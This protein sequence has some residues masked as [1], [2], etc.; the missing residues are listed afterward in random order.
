MASERRS[1]RQAKVIKKEPSFAIARSVTAEQEQEDP[2]NWIAIDLAKALPG[3]PI[4][5]SMQI[6]IEGVPDGARF[7]T[8]RNNGDKTWSLDPEDLAELSYLPPAGR[9]TENQSF[10]IRLLTYDPDGYQIAS[11]TAQVAVNVDGVTARRPIQLEHGE[12]GS[13][14]VDAIREFE[15]AQRLAEAERSWHEQE[16]ERIQQLETTWHNAM[17]ERL[18]A[19]EEEWRQ[20]EADRHQALNG[21]LTDLARRLR[22][23]EMEWHRVE[24]ERISAA[25]AQAADFT[26]QRFAAAEEQWRNE[27]E[28]QIAEVE[29]AAEERIAQARAEADKDAESRFNIHAAKFA[30]QLEDRQRS[31]L[32]QADARLKEMESA[33]ERLKLEA[34]ANRLANKREFSERQAAW[35][36]ERAA[37]LASASHDIE[38]ADKIAALEE[39]WRSEAQR[40][41]EEAEARIRR[42]AEQHLAQAEASW[43]QIAERRIV[44]A[45]RE[46]EDAAERRLAE[47]N[48]SV[49]ARSE[50]HVADMRGR[51]A[52]VERL[53]AEAE[54]RIALSEQQVSQAVVERQRAEQELA[55]AGQRFQEEYDRRLREAEGAWHAA[56]SDQLTAAQAAWTAA[57]AERLAEAQALWMSDEDERLQTA[58]A[59]ERVMLAGSDVGQMLNQTESRWREAEAERLKAAEERWKMEEDQRVAAAVAAAHEDMERMVEARLHRELAVDAR[60]LV[61]RSGRGNVSSLLRFAAGGAAAATIAGLLYIGAPQIKALIPEPGVAVAADPAAVPNDDSQRVEP[62]ASTLTVAAD[63]V[64][65]RSEPS[66]NATIVARL[67][68][69]TAVVARERRN[70]WVNVAD[71]GGG[72]EGWIYSALLDGPLPPEN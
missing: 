65:L 53:A 12:G 32:D 39:R 46:W 13:G 60:R 61:A 21:Q 14:A 67:E 38:T 33:F 66:S 17:E 36:L 27:A 25:L 8:G 63:F 24:S 7:S 59:A 52:E 19:A 51:M 3:I 43:A 70:N 15:F 23:T 45:Q 9:N 30:Q 5:D 37:L 48:D 54:R 55:A 34:E 2:E 35:E 64:N 58:I 69:G 71:P 6:I 42:E 26:A 44:E 1:G 62:A 18:R 20:A 11:T 68:R 56:Q 50:Q 10:F 28:R 16:A 4:T 22:E 47:R 49:I 31:E 72:S 41:V 29:Q 40:Q 57:E